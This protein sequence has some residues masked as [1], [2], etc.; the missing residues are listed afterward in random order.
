[1]AAAL[2]TYALILDGS[3]VNVSVPMD[4]P[5]FAPGFRVV[6]CPPDTVIHQTFVNG[7]FGPVVEVPPPAEAVPMTISD[8]QFAEGLWHEGIIAY[9]EFL[10]F[11]GPGTIPKALQDILD[12]LPDDETG[13][14]TPRKV[15]IGLV[16]GAK[17][18]RRD[19][20]LV[21]IVRQAHGWTTEELDGRWRTWATL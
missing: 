1:M 8:R 12:T 15:A 18:Y 7:V 2:R 9:P 21:D 16:T 6:E 17:E 4:E 3:V 13:Q 10:A 19:N 14:P 11:V 20:P 5:P